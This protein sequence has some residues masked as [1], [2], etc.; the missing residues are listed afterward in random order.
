MERTEGSCGQ[1][2]TLLEGLWPVGGGWKVLCFLSGKR[3]MSK[4]ELITSWATRNARMLPEGMVTVFFWLR[5]PWPSP[6]KHM[7]PG[8]KTGP[9]PPASGSV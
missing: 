2:P 4:S 3:R 9:N 1:A 7:A 5:W 8:R 6:C